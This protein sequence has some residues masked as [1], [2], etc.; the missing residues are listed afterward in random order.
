M[1][2]MATLVGFYRCDRREDEHPL[3]AYESFLAAAANGPDDYDPWR[4]LFAA[5]GLGFDAEPTPDAVAAM[6]RLLDGVPERWRDA[7]LAWWPA[8][9]ID[10]WTGPEP[11]TV[12]SD[13]R[14]ARIERSSLGVGDERAKVP[15]QQRA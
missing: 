5:H 15:M 2:V 13:C 11:Q 4:G 12:Q 8:S 7:D 3:T 6:Q 1:F 9:A 14:R 10:M